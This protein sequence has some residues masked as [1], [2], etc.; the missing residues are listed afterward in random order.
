MK[1]TLLLLFVIPLFLALMVE[2]PMIVDSP[3]FWAMRLAFVETTGALTLI[4]MGSAVI[5]ATRRAWMDKRFGGLDKVY[6]LHKFVGIGTGIFALL[7][8]LSGG[9]FRKIA[10]IPPEIPTPKTAIPLTF[11]ENFNGF[12]RFLGEWAFYIG[13]V[14]LFIALLK[15]LISY[16]SFHLSHK[17]IPVIFLMGAAH[18]LYFMPARFWFSPI[19]WC[20][21][22]LITIPGIA[23]GLALL[24]GRL[25]KEKQIAAT[26][27]DFE[28]KADGTL[29]L[30]V[31]APD[32]PGHKAGQFLL[33][34][35]GNVAKFE[36]AHPFS[37][38]SS[39]DATK[40]TIRL[41]IKPLGDFTRNLHN[42]I[43]KNQSVHLE[44]PYGD[45]VFDDDPQTPQLWVAG[46]VGVTPFVARLQ[47]LAQKNVHVNNID[48]F[49]SQRDDSAYFINEM[50]ELSQ[51]TGVRLHLW[52]TRS[53]GHLSFDT[54]AKSFQPNAKVYF[55]GP[56]Q[57]GE[58]LC[59]HLKTQGLADKNFMRE[60]FEF[61]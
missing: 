59:K 25:E 16:R 30:V 10:T 38:A 24:E 3:D 48:F 19:G 20:I 50:R 18:G 8:F 4:W 42:I 26:I 21:L 17:I 22:V 49:C 13:A 31:T 56:F 12:F 14:L 37:I 51:K 7:H 34:N 11:L 15:K 55:C 39:W 44:G 53:Q 58:N 9:L 45:F 60:R 2:L 33:I 6:H 35:F 57:W 43:H 32:W 23:F 29:E 52:L 1:R 5:L 47:D 40:K 46:G 28:K 36:G 54:I 27:T 61:R 41:G